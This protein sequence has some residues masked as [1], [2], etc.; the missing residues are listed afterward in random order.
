MRI[1]TITA[2]SLMLAVAA[3]AH[4]R[5][6]PRESR[7]GA[8]ET[9]SARVPTEGK[10]ATISVKLDVPA[11]VGI[12]SAA[13]SPQGDAILNK[14]GDRVIGVTWNVKIEPGA[15][16]ELT[17]VA[18]NPIAGDEI[19]WKVHQRYADGSTSEWVGGSWTR[20]PATVTKLTGSSQGASADAAITSW[21]A[22]YDDAF[23]AKSLDRLAAFYHPDVTIFEGGGVNIGWADYR[24][25]HIGPELKEFEAPRFSHQNIAV[26]QLSR[27]GD[28]AYVTSEYALKARVK[29]RDIDSGGLETLVLVK[30]AAGAWK[31]RHSHTSAKRRGPAAGAGLQ[32]KH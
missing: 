21:L 22:E 5:I 14:E 9:Y 13:A 30:D 28:A 2:I 7:A 32:P 16:A 8:T 10:V 12:V 24:D 6:T 15:F 19:V 31:I 26:H 25:N 17:Y 29:G 11:D 4:V 20:A 18:R 3:E 1:A 27:N 23:N